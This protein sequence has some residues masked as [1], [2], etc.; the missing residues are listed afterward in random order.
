MTPSMNFGL[1]MSGAGVLKKAE[2]YNLLTAISVQEADWK[3]V[4]ETETFYTP[5]LLS[6]EVNF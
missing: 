4:G 2:C 5:K 3:L 1:L 6:K